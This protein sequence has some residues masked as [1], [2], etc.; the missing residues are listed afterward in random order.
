MDN[1]LRV[2]DNALS[3]ELCDEAILR[4]N[5]LI[6]RRK[7]DDKY[8]EEVRFDN[9]ESRNDVSIFPNNFASCQ[10]VKNGIRDSLEKHYLLYRKEYSIGTPFEEVYKNNPKLQKSSEGGG[11]C[12]WHS[13]QGP[14]G[15]A[16]RFLVWMFYLNTVTKGGHTEFLYQDI[17]FQPTKGQLLLWPASF[18]H[19][20]RA[21]PDLKEDK[22]IATGWFHF[23][24]KEE[25]SN[26]SFNS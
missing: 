2:Y 8:K 20:H 4:I 22:Y 15:N 14:G 5:E 21:A 11:F 9:D 19:T 10:N 13:E 7:A 12:S 26:N 16:S 25:M 1:F 23:P 24:V 6:E 18:T 17:S 3:D